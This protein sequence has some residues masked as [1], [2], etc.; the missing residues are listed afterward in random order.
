MSTLETGDREGAVVDV[1]LTERQLECLR[2]I[3][4]GKSST[5]IGA[6][7]NISGRTVDYHVAEICLRLDVRTRMQAVAYALQHGWLSE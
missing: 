2:W 6:I 7:L 1:H 4:R 5:D 3:S